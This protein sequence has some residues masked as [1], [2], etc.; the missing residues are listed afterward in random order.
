MNVF[1]VNTRPQTDDPRQFSGPGRISQRIIRVRFRQMGTELFQISQSL[2]DQKR[3]RSALGRVRQAAPQIPQPLS[4][5][6]SS[7]LPPFFSGF[8]LPGLSGLLFPNP[9]V[10]CGRMFC[11]PAFWRFSLR[12]LF[13]RSL[14]QRFLGSP[15]RLSILGNFRLPGNPRLSGRS[16]GCLRFLFLSTFSGAISARIWLFRPCPLRGQ[17]P[18]S[19]ERSCAPI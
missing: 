2:P 12:L 10:C 11:L 4:G 13:P 17:N 7:S 3:D 1:P 8:S 14:S 9:L 19:P 15:G 5:R 18:F 6:R 16:P